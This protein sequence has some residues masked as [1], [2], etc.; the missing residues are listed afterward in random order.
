MTLE[1]EQLGY[2]YDA[3]EPH[4]T[5]RT[6]ELHHSRLHRG[7]IAALENALAGTPAA[8]QCLT[9]IIRSSS[10][11][12]YRLATQVWNHAFYWRSM[13]PESRG[14]Q[15]AALRYLLTRD[16]GSVDDFQQ[17]F[18]TVAKGTP[19]PGWAW[20]VID[21][22]KLRVR[23]CSDLH[24][25]LLEGWQPLLVL[26]M[27]EHAYYLDYQDERDRYV[28]VFVEHLINWE[29]IENNIGRAT[30]SRQSQQSLDQ[31]T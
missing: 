7:Y 4:L 5:A 8:R 28:D 14:P 29:F 17:H 24:S 11:T 25:P 3:L 2:G 19:A 21:R 18:A 23:S 30:R 9:D 16:F 6:V 10:G 12:P 27:H 15:P 20:L 26:D 22:M 13:C 31:P 1:L